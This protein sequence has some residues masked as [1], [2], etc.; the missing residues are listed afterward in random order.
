MDLYAASVPVFQR[1]LGQLAGLLDIAETDVQARQLGADAL[2]QA[3]LAPNMLPFETQVQIVANF[4]LRACFPLA[5][6]AVPPYGD[7]PA[8]FDGLR[9]RLSRAAQLLG[10]LEPARFAASASR[11]IEERAGDA[12]LTLNGAEFLT[13][14]A[15]PNFFFHLTTA[16]LILRSHGLAIGKAQFDGFHAYSGAR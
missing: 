16:Y 5:G 15:L 6:E 7:F 13:Q 9:A 3:R 8:T 10:A 11:Q 1:Y 2:L 12:V 4:A 14:Y